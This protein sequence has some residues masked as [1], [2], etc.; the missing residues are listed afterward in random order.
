[1]AQVAS[2]GIHIVDILGRPVERIPEGQSVD[3]LKEIRITVAGT[4][5]GTSVDLAKLGIDVVAMG[6][7]G[8]DELGSFLIS[9]MSKYGIDVS[10]IIRKN[11]IQTSATML[12]IRPNGERPALH[13]TGA[14]GE[15]TI[16]D[17]DFNALS[18][19]KV[20]HF[21]GTSLLPKIDGEPTKKILQFAKEKGLITTF[22]LVAIKR[23]DL[24]DLIAPC[25]PYVDFFMPGLEEAEMMTGMKKRKDIIRFF[26]DRGAKTTVFKMGARGSSIACLR[27]GSIEEIQIPI[28][29]TTLVDTTGCGDA[30]CAGFIA[31]LLMGFDMQKRGLLGAAAAALVASGLGSDAGIV[32]LS[33]TIEF[34]EKGEK[35]YPKESW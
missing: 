21:G 19:A 14:N 3:L 6:A 20:L 8:N 7:V 10:C 24:L 18:N 30:Y 11:G 13:V 15:F 1:M 23:P 17:V 25:L 5:A 4:A 32:D 34:M 9:T 31:G 35:L 29:K 26:L 12:P 2:L 22:D 33:R 27:N 28:Y 16:E